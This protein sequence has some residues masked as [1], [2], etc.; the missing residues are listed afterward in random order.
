MSRPFVFSKQKADQLLEMIRDG[1]TQEQA[2]RAVGVTRSTLLRWLREGG[3]GKQLFKEFY[4]S[5]GEAAKERILK[6]RAAP[7][8]NEGSEPESRSYK[9]SAPTE[10][11]EDG[12]TKY[13]VHDAT[14]VP[15]SYPLADAF[16][17]DSLACPDCGSDAVARRLEQLP[18]IVGFL[19]EPPRATREG[20]PQD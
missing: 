8:F 6:R 9:M 11:P 19:I 16:G 15:Q 1:A 2:A 5:Y 13:P 10:W 17:M 12:E 14:H 18:R 4:D 7:I 20:G 3:Q